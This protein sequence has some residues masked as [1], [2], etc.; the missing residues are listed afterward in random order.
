[1]CGGGALQAEGQ[2]HLKRLLDSSGAQSGQLGR[3]LDREM[4]GG[5]SGCLGVNSTE[6]IYCLE[7]EVDQEGESERWCLVSASGPR[8]MER[9][10]RES[11]GKMTSCECLRGIREAVSSG[12]VRYLVWSSREELEGQRLEDAG[13]EAGGGRGLSPWGGVGRERKRPRTELWV[14]T[15]LKVAPGGVGRTKKGP[16]G[17]AVR[18]VR[19]GL[20]VRLRSQEGSCFKRESKWPEAWNNAEKQSEMWAEMWHGLTIETLPVT[21]VECW[22][23]VRSQGLRGGRW[24]VMEAVSGVL[25]S[26]GR[27]WRSG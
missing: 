10:A 27:A 12:H 14:G 19:R 11:L 22:V 21:L 13:G 23:G 16:V 4:A 6:G 26:R 17:A 9:E 2:E 7:M 3:D 25:L 20:A 24:V 1:M 5:T 8:M 18:E 15:H